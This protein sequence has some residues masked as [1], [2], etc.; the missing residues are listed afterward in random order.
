MFCPK[1]RKQFK[2]SIGI[3]SDCGC[4]LVKIFDYESVVDKTDSV[5]IF[6]TTIFHEAVFVE[7]LLKSNDIECVVLGGNTSFFT[8]SDMQSPINIMVEE[9]NRLKAQKVI[10]QY[11]EDLKNQPRNDKAEDCKEEYYTSNKYI[12][13]NSEEIQLVLKKI[14]KRQFMVIVVLLGSLPFMLCV[15]WIERNFIVGSGNKITEIAAIFWAVLFAYT[16]IITGL[17][18]CP[19]CGKYFYQNRIGYHNPFASKCLNCGIK[20]D[21]AFK[22]SK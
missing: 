12:C 13:N 6:T 10:D 17:S 20:L 7:S 18:R 11:Y 3:C 2:E 19:K 8:F 14:L 16:G 5:K 15:M 1:C 9:K 4:S 22:E 21:D